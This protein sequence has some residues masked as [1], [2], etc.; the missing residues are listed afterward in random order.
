VDEV[1]GSVAGG[2]ERGVSNSYALPFGADLDMDRMVGLKGSFIHVSTNVSR[3]TSLAADHAGNAISFQTRYKVVQNLRLAALAIEQNL[4]DGKV[5]ISGGRVSPL[6]YFNQSNLY[7]MFQ[8]NSVCFNPAVVPIQD[9]GLGFFSLW[10]LGRTL[11][12]RADQGILRAGRYL[13][14]QSVS[15]R[16]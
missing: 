5:N 9:R 2:Q 16:N 6:T 1:A 11:Q 7:C 10:E 3:G 15:Q 13:R 4:F 14:G 8:N 12:G